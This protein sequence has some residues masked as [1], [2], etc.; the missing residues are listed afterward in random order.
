MRWDRMVDG[1]SFVRERVGRILTEGLDIAGRHY[2]FLGYSNSGLREH[3]VSDKVL[4]DKI[5]LTPYF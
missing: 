3:T 1:D 2:E 4:S 5:T